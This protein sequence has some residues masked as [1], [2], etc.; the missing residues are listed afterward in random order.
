MTYNLKRREYYINRGG[1]SIEYNITYYE[2]R[3]VRSLKK[4]VSYVI[5]LLL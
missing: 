2:L 3:V 1:V 4:V 5:S